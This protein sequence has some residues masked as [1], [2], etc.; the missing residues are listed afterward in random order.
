MIFITTVMLTEGVQDVDPLL[1]KALI[2]SFVNHFVGASANDQP[3]AA[4]P[5]LP[6]AAAAAARQVPLLPLP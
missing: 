2:F 5:V 3:S 4:E 6:T 1:C